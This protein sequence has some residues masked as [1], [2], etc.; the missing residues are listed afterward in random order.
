MKFSNAPKICKLSLE[1]EFTVDIYCP[2]GDKWQSKTLLLA[3]F[4]PRLLIVKSLFDCPLTGV[5]F[6]NIWYLETEKIYKMLR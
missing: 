3:I 5:V 1:T 6:G 4:D 2:S